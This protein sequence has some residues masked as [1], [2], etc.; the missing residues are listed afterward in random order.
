MIEINVNLVFFTENNCLKDDNPFSEMISRLVGIISIDDELI[1]INETFL[2]LD[3]LM[4]RAL[5]LDSILDEIFIPIF[6]QFVDDSMGHKGIEQH[7]IQQWVF[8][9]ND[10]G[11]LSFKVTTNDR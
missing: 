1:V 9:L 10:K 5:V 6:P 4:R 3:S 2:E 8:S 7:L 11:Y